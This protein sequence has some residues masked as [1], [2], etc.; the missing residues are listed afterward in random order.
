MNQSIIGKLLKQ[1]QQKYDSKGFS[2]AWEKEKDKVKQLIESAYKNL[3]KD[4]YVVG[5]CIAVAGSRIVFK[6]KNKNHKD[7]AL[8]ICRPLEDSVGM[9]QEEYSILK[10]L[11]HPN[12]IQIIDKANLSISGDPLEYLCTIE[13]FV[14]DGLDLGKWI[15][16]IKIS[17]INLNDLRKRVALFSEF[18]TQLSDVL[19][20][21]HKLSI[22]HCDIKPENVLI[23]DLSP[24]LVDFGYSHRIYP[25]N[26]DIQE[27]VGFSWDYALPKLQKDI[28][29][30]A[31][32]DAVFSDN[33]GNILYM[34]IDQYALGRT[35]EYCTSI[36]KNKIEELKKNAKEPEDSRS[37]IFQD[38]IYEIN[39]L[40]LIALRLKGV[41]AFDDKPDHQNIPPRLDKDMIQSIQFTL[42][43]SCWVDLKNALKNMKTDNLSSLSPEWQSKLGSTIRVGSLDVPFT[44]RLRKL[45]N[46]PALSR[47]SNVSQ[48]GLI[49][50]V[51]PSAKH[52]RLEHSL[53]TYYYAL[54]Y[55]KSLWEQKDDPIFRCLS[56]IEELEAASLGALFHDLGQYPHAHD[57]EDLNIV[58]FQHEQITYEM[59]RREFKTFGVKSLFEIVKENWGDTVAELIDK[60]LDPKRKV[61]VTNDIVGNILKNV[62]SSSIDADKLDYLQR[63]AA[64]LGLKYSSSVEIERLI[65]SLRPAISPKRSNRPPLVKL[66]VTLK[67][68]LSARSLVVARENMFERVYWHKTVRSLKSMLFTAIMLSEESDKKQ[69]QKKIRKV[70]LDDRFFMGI[71]IKHLYPQSFH[72]SYSDITFLNLIYDTIKNKSSKHLLDLIF[73]RR[74]YKRIFDLTSSDWE[75]SSNESDIEKIV[76]KLNGMKNSGSNGILQIKQFQEKLNQNILNDMNINLKDIPKEIANQ[77][78]FIIDLPPQ[79]IMGQYIYLVDAT[80]SEIKEEDPSF[81]LTGSKKV[82][83][84]SLSP[85]IYMHPDF[86]FEEEHDNNKF[87]SILKDSI[88]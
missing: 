13:E 74:P 51:Y 3:L 69:L 10:E 48:L 15:K 18:I 33:E 43:Y 79:R 7:Y 21:L 40:E 62:I 36:F 20:Y 19:G 12:L 27:T 41:D 61:N 16:S 82:S 31:S 71:G 24:K 88:C 76:Q 77:I 1:I 49:S 78:G 57:I 59:Y 22:Y 58:N 68:V 81:L 54:Q 34:R 47:L 2:E 42:H 8:K 80:K 70:I 46:H 23:K 87:L 35:I 4:D 30:F 50:Y 17:P 25:K 39:Y 75:R 65:L 72:L 5:D 85:R 38:T 9:L 44:T 63:D 6:I 45:I 73:L 86:E 29:S 64:N 66:G 28:K 52:S 60:Y 26:S 32:K 83:T 53:G 14:P 67:G 37:E 11:Y 56:T 55:I 84:R